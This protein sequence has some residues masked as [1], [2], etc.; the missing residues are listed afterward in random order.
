MKYPGGYQIIDLGDFSTATSSN[1]K[2]IPGIYEKIRTS[3]KPVI[4]TFDGTDTYSKT[5]QDYNGAVFMTDAT[6]PGQA[7]GCAF[8]CQGLSG[9]DLKI[10]FFWGIFI[11]EGDDV[12]P[13]EL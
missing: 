7:D 13:Y 3:K 6:Y 8:A 5:A 10:G 9:N 4:I 2:N 11:T 1:P 12:F